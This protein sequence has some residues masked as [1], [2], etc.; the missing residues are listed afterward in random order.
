[1]AKAESPVKTGD[2]IDGKYRVE[3]VLGTGGQGVVVSARHVE[4]NQ[5]VA[6]KFMLADALGDQE[7]LQRFLREARAAVRLKS[8]HTARV[9]DVGRMAK[10]GAPY[11]V[12]EF[13]VGRDVTEALAE[14]GP[15]RVPDA[16]ELIL[17][18]CEGIAEAH[19][20]GITHRDLTPRNLF[21]TRK[22]DGS[23]L[24]KAPDF[25]LAKA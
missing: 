25:G 14:T 8:E 3:R 7:T 16:A 4:L 10:T 11:M 15:M 21:L 1:M 24:I 18:A 5:R 22:V 23:P 12:M 19:A 9:L 20:A 2:V 6:L 17:Q 13:L